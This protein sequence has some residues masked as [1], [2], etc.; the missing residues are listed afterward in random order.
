LH[1]VGSIDEIAAADRAGAALLVVAPVEDASA[2][3]HVEVLAPNGDLHLA[4]A[5]LFAALRRL[6]ASGHARI[7]AVAI[8]EHGL[9]LAIMDRLRRA[10]VTDH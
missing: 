9:G 1:L 3:A 5:N 10:A 6:D 4:A 7:F 2:F 8:P